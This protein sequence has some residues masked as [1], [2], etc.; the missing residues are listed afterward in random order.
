MGA[1]ATTPCQLSPLSSL[2]LWLLGRYFRSFYPS[3]HLHQGCSGLTPESI[4]ARQS[5]CQNQ[6]Q[7]LTKEGPGDPAGPKPLLLC[8]PHPF[9]SPP[10]SHLATGLRAAFPLTRHAATSGPVHLKF[11]RLDSSSASLCS[12]LNLTSLQPLLR[13]TLL[14]WQ[15]HL[16]IPAHRPCSAFSIFLTLSD[17]PR[18]FFLFFSFFFR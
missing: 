11:M 6:V 12:A 16:L 15:P 18:R 5:R 3:T 1:V 13:C 14:K 9:C 7:V 8:R 4:V 2:G 10:Q 17:L